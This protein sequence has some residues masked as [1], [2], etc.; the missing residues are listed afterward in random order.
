MQLWAALVRMQSS[1]FVFSFEWIF[2]GVMTTMRPSSHPSI[3]VFVDFPFVAF[4]FLLRMEEKYVQ[5]KQSPK[6]LIL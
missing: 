5:T 4:L 6:H 3:H 2:F 1:W